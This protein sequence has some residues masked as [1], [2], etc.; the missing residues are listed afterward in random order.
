MRFQVFDLIAYQALFP[1]QALKQIPD[2]FPVQVPVSLPVQILCLPPAQVPVLLPAQLPLQVPE[3]A[4]EQE[5]APEQ[6]R[7]AL[8]GRAPKQEPVSIQI[9][10]CRIWYKI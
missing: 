6:K 2:S 7:T 10:R 4:A 3:Q 8:C 1:V 9:R 5:Q